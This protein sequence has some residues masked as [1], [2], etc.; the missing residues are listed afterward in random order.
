MTTYNKTVSESITLLE[1][2]KGAYAFEESL[3]FS[4]TITGSKSRK[5]DESL[6][7]SE[8]VTVNMSWSVLVAESLSLSEP[9]YAKTADTVQGSSDVTPDTGLLGA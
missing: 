5:I 2:Q 4:E 8:I 7:L 6:S 1:G 9:F 3:S